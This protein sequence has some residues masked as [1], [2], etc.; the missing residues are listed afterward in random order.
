MV[1]PAALT[2][3]ATETGSPKN[4]VK[5]WALKE[6]ATSGAIMETSA[7]KPRHLQIVSCRDMSSDQ[8]VTN[9]TVWLNPLRPLK[10]PKLRIKFWVLLDMEM[11]K[12]FTPAINPLLPS[13]QNSLTRKNHAR[14]NGKSSGM[15]LKSLSMMLWR[16][17]DTF[18]NILSLSLPELLPLALR[19]LYQLKPPLL[20]LHVLQNTL[21]K[22]L[23]WWKLLMTVLIVLNWHLESSNLSTTLINKD[24]ST[25]KL[26]NS[27]EKFTDT[28]RLAFISQKMYWLLLKVLLH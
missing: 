23:L 14:A 5:R 7:N 12:L 27:L 16:L 10:S 4:V 13:L 2:M 3:T 6:I 25:M 20:V 22:P 26:V 11:P 19:K 28:E 15:R 21:M 24:S 17:L 18:V 1:N 9:P 8:P